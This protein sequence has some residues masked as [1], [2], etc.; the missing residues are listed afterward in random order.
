MIGKKPITEYEKQENDLL[1]DLRDR[2]V[3]AFGTL[4]EAENIPMDEIGKLY[5]LPRD[6]RI[7]LF[8]QQGDLSREI[9]ELLDDNGYQVLDLTGGYREWIVRRFI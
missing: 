8:C 4:P 7:V 9:A 6:K 1:I 2:T 3:F 5:S